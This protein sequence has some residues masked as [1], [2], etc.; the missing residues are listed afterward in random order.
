MK[1]IVFYF[2]LFLF[3]I[4]SSTL[5]G[6]ILKNKQIVTQTF[7]SYEKQTGEQ[8]LAVSNYVRIN[9]NEIVAF[10]VKNFLS[11]I[12]LQVGEDV[13]IPYSIVN[14]GNFPEKF[15]LLIKNPEIFSKYDV[16]LDKNKNGIL[17]ANEELIRLK[18]IGEHTYEIPITEVAGYTNIII[19]GNLLTTLDVNIID[20]D[21]KVRSVSQSTI[22]KDVNNKF[23]IYSKRSVDVRKGI[24]F[25]KDKNQY[26]FTFKFLNES[27]TSVEKLFLEDDLNPDFKLNSAYGLW[28]DFGKN[29]KENV[30]FFLDG[31]EEKAPKLK[32]S[33][34]NGKL[35]V[36][37]KDIPSQN[38][39]D[40]GG[41]LFIPFYVE[42]S[43]A[44]DKKITNIAKFNYIL[45][46]IAS[47]SYLTNEVVFFRKY[48]PLLIKE[49]KQEQKLLTIGDR[50]IFEITS[51]ITN[52]GNGADTFN[53]LLKNSNFPNEVILSNLSD[54]NG[55]GILDTGLLNIGETKEIT[56]RGVINKDQI[57]NSY[58]LNVLFNSLKAKDYS[59]SIGKVFDLNVKSDNI[60]FL[61]EQRIET[62]KYTVN[63]ID[64]KNKDKIYYRI[65][66]E[67]KDKN[68]SLDL[69]EV[70][71]TIPIGTKVS[72]G[73]GELEEGG[74]PIYKIGEKGIFQEIKLS[75]GGTELK[76]ENVTVPPNEKLIIYFNVEVF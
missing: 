40:E 44:E 25:D 73:T 76:I 59:M 72:M 65:T 21:F 14:N 74:K 10:E 49:G 35:K 15:L 63:L 28:Q 11:T 70:Y 66:L 23:N 51:R 3:V 58:S 50:Y 31:Y 45:N 48:T 16:F 33:L 68:L 54:T 12:N 55:D 7:L 9:V 34:V 75:E 52:N 53:V 57:N 36:E 43:L 6:E 22:E 32:V 1:K 18:K 61:K 38:K 4:I 13:E 26:Y 60:K 27:L 5:N 71:D 29:E 37:I 67:N 41:I 56:I 47:E 2:Y 19:K 24:Y 62:G 39:I 64:V 42:N 17:E 20:F 69:S 8:F 46:N 30:T